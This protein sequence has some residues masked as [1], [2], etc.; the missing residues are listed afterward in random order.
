MKKSEVSDTQEQKLKS[1]VSQSAMTTIFSPILLTM[2]YL[3]LNFIS[4]S[5]S[6]DLHTFCFVAIAIVA[7]SISDLLDAYSRITG[8]HALD[9]IPAARSLKRFKHNTSLPAFS[10]TK[11]FFMV[12]LAITALGYLVSDYLTESVLVTSVPSVTYNRLALIISSLAVIAVCLLSIAGKPSSYD[13]TKSNK[14]VEA[15]LILCFMLIGALSIHNGHTNF[16]TVKFNNGSTVKELRVSYIVTS[17]LLPSELITPTIYGNE[18]LAIKLISTLNG[19][20]FAQNPLLSSVV[21][22]ALLSNATINLNKERNYPPLSHLLSKKGYQERDIESLNYFL[23]GNYEAYV[24]SCLKIIR[25]SKGT[26]TR[27]SYAVS[28]LLHLVDGGLLKIKGIDTQFI[29]EPVGKE[30]IRDIT[31]LITTHEFLSS[32]STIIV[33]N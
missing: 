3:G 12:I 30:R 18:K 25:E 28:L 14:K 1:I 7:S 22:K 16:A 29:L 32:P 2:L 5:G 13:V 8:S 4:G 6:L 31:E 24:N 27:G 11:Q 19:N 17:D 33:V 15:G 9:I 26:N 10:L 21:A 20:D 23:R